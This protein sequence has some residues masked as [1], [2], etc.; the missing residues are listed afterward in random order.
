MEVVHILPTAVAI[1]PYPFHNDIKDI[2]LSEVKEQEENASVAENSG[3]EI[4]LVKGNEENLKI[5]T[6][7]DFKI[8]ES[9]IKK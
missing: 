7:I 9:L 6:P 1:I 5:T 3:M 4:Y 8:A 2:I